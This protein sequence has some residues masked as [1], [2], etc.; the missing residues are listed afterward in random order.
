MREFQ[1]EKIDAPGVLDVKQILSVWEASVRETHHF[2]TEENILS[3]RP[4]VELALPHVELFAARNARG[5]IEAFMGVRDKKIEMLFLA[6]GARGKGMGARFIA[7]AVHTLGAKFVDV[8]EQNGQAA[9]FY[10]HMGFE[11]FDRSE[12]DE[13]G[14][15]FPILRMRLKNEKD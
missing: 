14:N 5:N 13:Q 10:E 8:N 11:T 9:G 7:Y 12:K 6:P 1:I 15:P 3:I 2:L 4:L